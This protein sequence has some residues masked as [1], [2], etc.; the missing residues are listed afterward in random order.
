MRRLF[1]LFF[2]L[3]FLSHPDRGFGMAK[4]REQESAKPAATA[5]PS[6]TQDGSAGAGGVR[7]AAS[8]SAS[9]SPSSDKPQQDPAA[10]RNALDLAGEFSNEGYKIRDGYWQRA[11]AESGEQLIAVNLFSGNAYWF[12]VAGDGPAEKEEE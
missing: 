4:P 11:L 3:F 6:A 7:V 1:S 8:V 12:C 2:L 5:Q 10:R 9:P